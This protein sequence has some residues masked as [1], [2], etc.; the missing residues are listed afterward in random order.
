[1]SAMPSPLVVPAVPLM[2]EARS[3]LHA[4]RVVTRADGADRSLA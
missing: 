4:E 2:A 3:L 1:M